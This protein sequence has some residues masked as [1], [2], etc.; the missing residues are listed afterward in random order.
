MSPDLDIFLPYSNCLLRATKPHCGPCTS[1]TGFCFK[2]IVKKPDVVQL[3]INGEMQSSVSAMTT[4]FLAEL[5]VYTTVSRHRNITAFLGC[6][7]NV[8]MV[9][10][11]ID[12]RTLYEVICLRPTLTRAQKI[13]FYN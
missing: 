7:E 1:G 8:D 11:Y 3:E 5:R 4:Q 12:G 2:C 9:L 6:L 13:D 10:E